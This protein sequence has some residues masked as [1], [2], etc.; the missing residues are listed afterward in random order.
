MHTV[1]VVYTVYMYLLI[2]SVHLNDLF[3]RICFC[4][5]H[6]NRVVSK[7]RCAQTA[8]HS[9]LPRLPRL[10]R[11]SR[12]RRTLLNTPLF[13]VYSSIVTRCLLFLLATSA[14]CSLLVLA[15]SSAAFCLCMSLVCWYWCASFYR[16][17]VKSCGNT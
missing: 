5:F 6:L 14:C 2:L 8:Y 7:L 9:A 1:V 12:T 11:S 13:S 10:P 4:S 15:S 16:R 17:A 3:T